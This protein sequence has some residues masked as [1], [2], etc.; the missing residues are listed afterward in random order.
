MAVVFDTHTATRFANLALA[1]IH[2]EYPN[3]VAHAMNSRMFYH[4]GS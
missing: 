2:R 4:R 1:C 3:K